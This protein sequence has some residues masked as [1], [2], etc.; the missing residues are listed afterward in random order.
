MSVEMFGAAVTALISEFVG[1]TT[2]EVVAMGG[3]PGEAKRRPSEAPCDSELS[4]G[5]ISC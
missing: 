4:V 1:V 3:L 5:G 2:V